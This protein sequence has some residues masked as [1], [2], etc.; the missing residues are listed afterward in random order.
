VPRHGR[1]GS[2]YQIVV[3][4][5]ELDP[6]AVARHY[7]GIGPQVDPTVDGHQFVRRKTIF[8]QDMSYRLRNAHDPADIRAP[9][10]EPAEQATIDVEIDSPNGDEGEL[11]MEEFRPQ[12]DS[13]G[14]GRMQMQDVEFVLLAASRDAPAGHKVD[15]ATHPDR[16]TW[17]VLAFAE[18]LKG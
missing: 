8:Q 4:N 3:G 11:T 2:Y 5:S 16:N 1:D 7:F 6:E 9:V 17:Q 13:Q 10:L 18:S 12:P 15:L 14:V